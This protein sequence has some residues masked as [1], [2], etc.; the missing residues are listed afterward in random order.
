MK[1]DQPI[2]FD[3]A[4]AV[5]S[6]PADSM[7][8][9]M[10]LTNG[11]RRKQFG[12]KAR[13]CSIMNAKSGACSGDCHFCAQ[14][15]RHAT[16]VQVYPLRSSKQ[17]ADA[18]Q[19]AGRS[20]PVDHFGIVTSGERLSAKDVGRIRD[21]IKNTRMEELRWCASLGTLDREE[22]SALKNAGLTRFH[23]NLET[24]ESFFP[25]I[26]TTHTWRER[27]EMV[28]LAKSVGL[29]TCSGGILGLGETLSQRVELAMTLRDEAVDSIP[30]NFLVPLPG[31]ELEHLE[32]MKPMDI[33]RTIAMFRLVNI[34]AEIKVC[35]GRAHMRDL[36]SM[37]FFAGATGM[38]I[39]P[40]L[41]IA[42]R[43]V[44]SDIAMLMDLEMPFEIE[45]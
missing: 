24:A 29:E 8:D 11:L 30:L 28:R 43:D 18:Y 33:L 9:L 15:S 45:R 38:M 20:L 40:L 14:S 23:H 12:R 39:G 10:A 25:K 42:G 5:L 7:P 34:K 36:Q 17:M 13:L 44:Q 6:T 19:E 16:G 27:L 26:C 22:L 21:T 37:I 31:T 32:P 35:A 4:L 41:T 1:S 3:A 2:A